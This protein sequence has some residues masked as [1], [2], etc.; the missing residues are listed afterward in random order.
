MCV[1]K[2]VSIFIAG[3]IFAW[4]GL[5]GCSSSK[6][7][8]QP[9]N[10]ILVIGSQFDIGGSIDPKQGL[11]GPSLSP[12]L[13]VFEPLVYFDENY[14]MQPLLITAW[15]P[16]N[17]AKTWTVQLRKGVSFTDGTLFNAETLIF[18][19]RYMS[20]PRS[21]LSNIQAMDMVDEYTL[22]FSLKQPDAIFMHTLSSLGQMSPTCVDKDGRFIKPVGTG[23]FKFVE[24]IEGRRLVYQKNENYW[25]E[26]PK[27]DQVIIKMIPDFNTRA[28]ALESGE[29]DVADYLPAEVLKELEAD[30]HFTV[31][32]KIPSPCPNWIGMNTKR[33]PF[34][35]V[36]IR[37]A[38]NYA[39]DVEGIV[40]KLI[41]SILPDLAVP[42]TRGPHSQPLFSHIMNPDLKWY[43]HDTA[44][45]RQLLSDA[46]W[47]DTDGDGVV[48]KNGNPFRAELISSLLY[49]EGTEIAEAVQSQLK[50]VGMDISVRVLESGARFQAYREKKY[51]L[52]E[53]AGICPHND[54]SPWYEYFFHSRKQRAY[55]I[56]EDPVIDA[57]IDKL[58]SAVD[59]ESRKE[60]FYR[61]QSLLEK[62][63]PG[64]FFIQP[65]GSHGVQ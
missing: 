64:I 15:D 43:G 18:S 27:V 24:Y 51:D 61:L 16:S 3:C 55:A 26:K 54:P 23:P 60:S 14:K 22:R 63:A 59:Q 45:A 46:G 40:D 36:R 53:L 35:D 17:D 28:M 4:V 29:I 58:S 34:N 21:K 39:V 10:K 56:M 13:L 8:G 5:F 48:E 12:K 25:G 2:S 31:I 1:K 42:A 19:V 41:N 38:V 50:A 7:D 52:I 32:R 44:K 11:G 30:P 37:K 6:D 49:A 9:D 33:E 62:N 65:A 47:K 57:E 20:G